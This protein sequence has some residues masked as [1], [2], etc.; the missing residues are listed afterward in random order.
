[1]LQWE[2]PEFDGG[3]PLTNYIVECREVET[4]A[5]ESAE[6]WRKVVTVQATTLQHRVENIRA[7]RLLEFR[8]SAENALGVGLPAC[9]EPVRLVTHASEYMLITAAK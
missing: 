2:P 3:S 6:T 5:A 4:A 9:C 7:R 1:M 8:V